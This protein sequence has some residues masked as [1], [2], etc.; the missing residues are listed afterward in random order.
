MVK[1]DWAR[2]YTLW[3][4]RQEVDSGAKL[5]DFCTETGMKF[6]TA[7]VQ[8]RKL[9]KT[10]PNPR[11]LL[12]EVQDGWNSAKSRI[13]APD[14]LLFPGTLRRLVDEGFVSPAIASIL[15]QQA[16]TAQ[17]LIEETERRRLAL[18][19]LILNPPPPPKKT[20]DEGASPRPASPETE[21]F[22]LLVTATSKISA[23]ESTLISTWGQLTNIQASK[24]EADRKQRRD[25]YETYCKEQLAA[26][27]KLKIK[28][29]WSYTQLSEHLIAK[30]VHDFPPIFMLQV[31]A[32]TEID[33]SDD[34]N[35][36]EYNAVT[37]DEL[38]QRRLEQD[39]RL[40][41]ERELLAEK[42]AVI[43]EMRGEV[44]SAGA[45]NQ[46]PGLD[47][48]TEDDSADADD[49]DD[50]GVCEVVNRVKGGAL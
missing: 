20:D 25:A 31:R 35:A 6:N 9:E 21:L 28:N 2:M 46:H 26:G 33:D 32:E 5:Q 17:D 19:K 50:D 12:V 3:Q 14:S 43:D 45:L 23:L 44:Y 49:Y 22:T 24:Q 37:D 1:M 10:A 4:Q 18:A 48:F 27:M 7:R 13:D 38:L 39:K 47:E 34:G 8:F 40:A 29:G 36:I 30:G 42:D 15:F 16:K 41:L 11:P